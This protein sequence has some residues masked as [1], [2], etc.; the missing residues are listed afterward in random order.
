VHLTGHHDRVA[1]PKLLRRSQV[2]M[3]HDGTGGNGPRLRNVE[4]LS[5]TMSANVRLKVPRLVKPTS[6]QMSV[7]VRSVER[8]RYI[9]RSTRRRC[10][11]RCGVSPNVAL[12]RRLKCAGETNATRASAG[13]SN[14]HAKSR[15]IAS[16]ARNRRRFSSSTFTTR[17]S[18]VR[19]PSDRCRDRG[20]RQQC[21]DG[22]E[23]CSD[24]DSL[25]LQFDIFRKAG[26]H[27]P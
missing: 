9:A 6:M 2:L 17:T 21:T 3:K 12:K 26:E 4:G 13:T 27:L 14:G 10:R 15:S 18:R 25:F 20:S 16:R 24:L 22:G 23:Y 5:P 19:T 1:S 11:Y 7:T 8:K